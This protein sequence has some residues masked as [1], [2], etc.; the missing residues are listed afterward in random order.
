MW[1]SQTSLQIMISGRDE[2]ALLVKQNRIRY[3][4]S[5][6]GLGKV[7]V[8]QYRSTF[9]GL[10]NMSSVEGRD[11]I[12][13]LNMSASTWGLLDEGQLRYLPTEI[14]GDKIEPHV[15]GTPASLNDV[16]GLFRQYTE[17]FER[18]GNGSSVSEALG[19]LVL[20]ECK[21]ASWE[22]LVDVGPKTQVLTLPA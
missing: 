3:A 18:I 11:R 2:D 7:L 12:L 20:P 5:Y 22:Q 4:T 10:I 8:S 9:T 6:Y 17:A 13:G 14:M 21:L 1:R 19:G 16:V 15:N